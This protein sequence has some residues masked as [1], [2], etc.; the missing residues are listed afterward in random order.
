MVRIKICG[1][2]NLEDALQA[3]DLGADAVGFIFY[4]G[5]PRNISPETA[6]AIID[7][8]PPFLTRV[9]VFVDKSIEEI[10]EIAR[11][12]G[13]DAVQLHG[14]Q[15][16]EVID[17]LRINTIKSIRLRSGDDLNQ[18]ANYGRVYA[19]LLDTF[20]ERE[21]GGT[22][23]T[24]N[25]QWAVDAKKFGRPIILSGGLTPENVTEAV[26]LAKPAAVD[27]SSGVESVPGKKD[28][29]KLARFIQAA[30]VRD[31]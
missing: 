31:A 21:F 16:P 15:Q 28:Y 23:K 27:V 20:D 25:W 6:A 30:K 4:R 1:I 9:G 8:L 26:R 12:C 24:F 22:G 11:F 18:L 7:K 13:L 19:F 29:Q 17:N 5:S 3:A 14:D 2:T 10:E